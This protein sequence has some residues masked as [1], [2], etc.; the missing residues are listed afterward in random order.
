MEILENSPKKKLIVE[1][2]KF[3]AALGS[4]LKTKPIK[5]E[6][7]KAGKKRDPKTPILAKQ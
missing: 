1:K 2:G 7:I 6:A 5:R 3:D 4:L